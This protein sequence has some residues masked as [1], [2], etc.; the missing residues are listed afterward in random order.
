MTILL[1]LNYFNNMDGYK[2]IRDDNPNASMDIWAH[3]SHFDESAKIIA[4]MD[5]REYNFLF[6]K[7]S[8]EEE[9]NKYV[10]LNWFKIPFDRKLDMCSAGFGNAIERALTIIDSDNTTETWKRIKS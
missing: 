8:T 3:R 9:Q 5:Y 7:E 1:M 2:W 6:G 4:M 10:D